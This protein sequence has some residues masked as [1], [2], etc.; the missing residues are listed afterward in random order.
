MTN[1]AAPCL[2]A[3]VRR[4][5]GARD[6]Y[7]PTRRAMACGVGTAIALVLLPAA[8][9]SAALWTYFPLPPSL[10]N[11]EQ[12]AP[13]PDGALWFTQAEFQRQTKAL[14]R[15]TTSGAV[16]QVAVPAGTS[17]LA[18]AAG[19]DGALWYAGMAAGGGRIGQVTAA[20]V[21][22]I[23]LPGEP[24][25]ANG[26]AAG[27]DGALWFTAFDRIGRRAPD[28]TLTFF[29]VPGARYLER[30]A[31]APDA[32]WFTDSQDSTI[33]RITTS[34]AMQR[35]RL[36]GSEADDIAIGPDGAVW[37]TIFDDERIGRITAD[38]RIRTYPLPYRPNSPRAITAGPDGA[39]WFTS[40]IFI[41]RVT[42][43]GEFTEFEVPDRRGYHFSFARGIVTG[44]D[45]A[46]WFTQND[47]ILDDDDLEVSKRRSQIGRIDRSRIDRVLVATLADTPLRGR[48]DR[49]L[50][51]DFAATRNAAGV[52]RLS[53]KGARTVS[54]RLRAR[55]GSN[56]VTVRLPR[57]PGRY[58]LRLRLSLPSQAATDTA[59]VTVTR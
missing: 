59:T 43:T 40:S 50:R 36:P 35:F 29:P 12:I 34:G 38:G 23:G 22:E 21:N 54:R 42:P 18:V 33:G 28:G 26:I 4:G 20:G 10:R 52:L 51:L 5:G 24:L 15:I 56:S 47:E 49:M 16:S 7:R 27:P 37:F 2:R 44:P 55:P 30:I 48:A 11:A 17:A 1:R 45:G 41:G 6:R 13:G 53:R 25:S 32:L 57:K 31:A 3:I 46:I 19:P 9:A 14:G 8:P 58:E 39:L